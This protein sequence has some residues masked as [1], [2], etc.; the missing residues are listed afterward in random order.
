MKL[1]T[2]RQI[3]EIGRILLPRELRKEFQIDAETD[4]DIYADG[5]RIVLQKTLPACRICGEKNNLT[6]M[7]GKG[8]YICVDCRRSVQEMEAS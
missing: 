5:E 6:Q 3:D 8:I 7:A 1:V 2:T 4:L